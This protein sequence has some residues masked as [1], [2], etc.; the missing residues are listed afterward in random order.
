MNGPAQDEFVIARIK[1]IMPYGAFCVLED[2]PGVEAFVHISEVSPGWVKNIHEYLREG[3]TAVARV[4]RLIPEKNQIDLSIK[5]VSEAE[6]KRKLESIRRGR[7]AEKLI[8]LVQRTLK[9]PDAKKQKT[10]ELLNSSFGDVLA[11]FEAALEE[12]EEPLERVGVEKEIA[13]AISDIAK[14]S[15]KKQK[16]EV[17]A[18]LSLIC[19]SPNGL[20][21]I[22][23]SLSSITAPQGAECS[24]T[25]L[26][27]PRYQLKVLASDFKDAEKALDA[28]VA[29]IEKTIKGQDAS[30]THSRIET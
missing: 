19:Y 22:K 20:E 16:A 26:G 10:I 4:Y 12:G 5:R 21:T 11:A 28:I 27:S 6:K 7:R 30:F 3:Q 23:K 1:K 29:Q 13:Q 9:M 2:Y 8:E 15:I 17:E 18:T 24:I 14:K 25:F